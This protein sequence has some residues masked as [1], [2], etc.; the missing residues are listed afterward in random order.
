MSLPPISKDPLF[1]YINAN[2]VRVS[3]WYGVLDDV[4]SGGGNGGSV[5]AVVV[6]VMMI[7]VVVV[8]VVAS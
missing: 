8:E 1:V 7:V 2:I 5:V 6:V 3:W 4:D